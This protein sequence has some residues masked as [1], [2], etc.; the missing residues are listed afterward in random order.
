MFRL[1]E[2]PLERMDAKCIR[3]CIF[4]LSFCGHLEPQLTDT[5]IAYILAEEKTL[6]RRLLNVLLNYMYLFGYTPENCEKF[7][8][9]VKEKTIR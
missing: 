8:D 3:D 1:K 7:I 9:A 5:M 4:N 6:H 2:I